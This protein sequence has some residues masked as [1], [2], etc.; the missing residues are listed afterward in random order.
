MDFLVGICQ[1]QLKSLEFKGYHSRGKSKLAV[2]YLGSVLANSC[3]SYLWSNQIPVRVSPDQLQEMLSLSH[4]SL[5]DLAGALPDVLSLSLFP[6]EGRASIQ[7]SKF[8]RLQTEHR[9]ECLHGKQRYE[10][11]IETLG[12]EEWWTIR[13]YCLPQGSDPYRLLPHETDQFCYQT[14]YSD[15]DVYRN[16][17]M[18][19]DDVRREGF[20]LRL[21]PYKRRAY[22]RLF[23]S[24]LL[25]R[26]NRLLIF[27]GLLEGLELG[28]IERN[29]LTHAIEEMNYYLDH[30]Y[31]VWDKITLGNPDIQQAADTETVRL[32]ELRAPSAS[33][34]DRQFV[35]DQMESGVLFK[36]ISGPDL[37][38]EIQ[39][40]I[41][42]VTSVIPSLKTFHKNMKYLGLAASIIKTHIIGQLRANETIYRAMSALWRRNRPDLCFLEFEEDCFMEIPRPRTPKLAYQQIFIAALRLFCPLS[43]AAPRCERGERRVTA[44]CDT[45]CLASFLRKAQR[46]GFNSQ[47]VE[48]T[49]LTLGNASPASLSRASEV[50]DHEELGLVRRC[51]IPFSRSYDRIRQSLFIP[52]LLSEQSLTA[53]PT[54]VFIQRDFVYSFLG[55]ITDIPKDISVSHA[56]AIS[57]TSL[58]QQQVND[59]L[60]QPSGPEY[61]SRQQASKVQ[62]ASNTDQSNLLG[63]QP[64]PPVDVSPQSR[65]NAEGMDLEGSQCLSGQRVDSGSTRSFIL[66]KSSGR[67]PEVRSILNR[68]HSSA[69]KTNTRASGDFDSSAR[70]FVDFKAWLMNQNSFEPRFIRNNNLLNDNEDTESYRSIITPEGLKKGTQ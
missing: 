68:G 1:L 50:M 58:E 49:L 57:D 2:E 44:N 55:E 24:K 7:N 19:P 56:P 51:G 69:N 45:S 52:Q 4:V 39:S 64:S 67:A 36:N 8:L 23:K 9:V 46:W 27:P 33:T 20:L 59:P 43:Q 66:P 22:R 21:T 14:P 62:H 41:L 53:H 13:I 63:D 17:Y 31:K 11:A 15:G 40:R 60:A 10:A 25:E 54:T 47:K 28:N 65:D 34:V 16:A 29:L 38:T 48:E 42:S 70:S 37:R 61:R 3:E 35:K 26:L 18:C 32:L 6:P 5:E 12:P 30:I